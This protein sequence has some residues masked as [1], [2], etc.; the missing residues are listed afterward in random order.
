MKSW[1]VT[2]IG[3]FFFDFTKRGSTKKLSE[4]SENFVLFYRHLLNIFLLHLSL[5]PLYFKRNR[6]KNKNVYYILCDQNFNVL[7]LTLISSKKFTRVFPF[8]LYLT[9]NHLRTRLKKQIQ[10]LLFTIINSNSH[11]LSVLVAKLDILS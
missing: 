10:I 1:R 9:G 4:W 5:L 7:D 2:G 3:K 6:Q 11:A 8:S